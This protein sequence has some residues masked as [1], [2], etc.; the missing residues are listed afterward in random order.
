MT[1]YKKWNCP[2]CG[3]D[4]LNILIQKQTSSPTSTNWVVKCNCGYSAFLDTSKN[5]AVFFQI[6]KYDEDYPSQ[7]R[8]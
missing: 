7:I 1:T 5:K 3:E 4:K 8:K 2:E 6:P